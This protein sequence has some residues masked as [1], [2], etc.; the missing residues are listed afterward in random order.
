VHEHVDP[1]PPLFSFVDH[2]GDIIGCGDIGPNRHRLTAG[3]GRGPDH[4]VCLLDT[5]P[6]VD[7][8]PVPAF[9][10]DQCG[11]RTD[12]PAGSGD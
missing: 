8:Q 7:D 1:A 5:G 3:R 11:R 9:G 6:V 2:C 10:E 4:L 12:A